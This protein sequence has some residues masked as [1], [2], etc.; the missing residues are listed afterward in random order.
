VPVHIC[1]PYASCRQSSYV[2]IFHA[3]STELDRFIGPEKTAH[4]L[5]DL[6]VL[7]V[8]LPRQSSKQSPKANYLSRTNYIYLLDLY[9][10]HVVSTFNTYSRGTTHRFLTDIDSDYHLEDADFT[11]HSSRPCQLKVLHFSLM[12]LSGLVLTPST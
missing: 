9:F 1:H 12:V 2:A 7:P 8:S 10:Q 6:W 11:H 4:L 3:D 5:T